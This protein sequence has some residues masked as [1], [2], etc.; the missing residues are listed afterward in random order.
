MSYVTRV[1]IGF[2]VHRL[3]RGR[4]LILG[5]L[6]IESTIGLEGHSDG[7]VLLHAVTDAILGACALGDIGDHFPSHEAQWKG[8]DSNTFLQ[9]AL[10]KAEE[11]GFVIANVDT[12]VVAERP[13]LGAWKIAIRASLAGRLDVPVDRVCVKAK[14]MEG[15]GPVGEG[16]AIE[17]HAVVLLKREKSAPKGAAAKRAKAAAKSAG[18]RA[19]GGRRKRTA[20]K[21]R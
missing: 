10:S 9:E 16:R 19:A 2:D 11:A 8:A 12:V 6:E 5:G 15:L 20:A 4:R 21:R 7:D 14:T 17:A 1:G 18:A 13:H 3:A